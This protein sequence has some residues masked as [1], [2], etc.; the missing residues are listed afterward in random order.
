MESK[1]PRRSRGRRRMVMVSRKHH[2]TIGQAVRANGGDAYDTGHGPDQRPPG[3]KGSMPWSRWEWKPERRPHGSG[4][5]IPRL[6]PHPGPPSCR[7]GRGSGKLHSRPACG[8]SRNAVFPC[9]YYFKHG[10]FIRRVGTFLKGIRSSG[11]SCGTGG[12]ESQPTQVHSRQ[13]N[14]VHGRQGRD[15]QHGAVPSESHQHAAPPDSP[16]QGIRRFND[17]EPSWRESSRRMMRN[18][19]PV[20]VFPP[21]RPGRYHGKNSCGRSCCIFRAAQL[22]NRIG[23]DLFRPALF[24]R[25]VTCFAPLI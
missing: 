22:V 8:R 7:T 4:S 19:S 6:S 18:A 9:P 5:A 16:F 15:G 1:R 11:S 2:G 25:P 3:G 14:A 13:G 21:A 24:M 20:P 12:H 10:T 17:A 23:K